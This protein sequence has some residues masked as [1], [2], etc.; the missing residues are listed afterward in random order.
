MKTVCV[1]LTRMLLV[2]GCAYVV[3]CRE[4]IPQKVRANSTTT[5]RKTLPS[6]P[7]AESR[8]LLVHSYHPEYPWVA[9]ITR[10]VQETLEGNGVEFEVFYMDTKRKTDERWKV[11]AGELAEQKVEE[12]KPD[13]VIAADDNAQQY[14][15][16]KYIGKPLP[17]VF[18]GVGADPSK[19]GYPAS[20][21]TGVLER[22]HFRSTLEYAHALR[23]IK[24]I[25]V[26]SS[27]DPTSVAAFAFMK[28]DYID[29][30]VVEW[31]LVSDFDKWKETVKRYNET[32]DAF[33]IR[34]YQTVKQPG[35]RENVAPREVMAW[36]AKHATVPT[37]AFHDFE[38]EDGVLMGVVKSG[39]EEGRKAARYAVE[40]LKGT[41]MS[42][43]PITRAN[44]G[45]KMIN[46]ETA[47][48]LG[49]ALTEEAMQGGR[50]VPE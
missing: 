22:P 35:S 2:A 45:T 13:V 40:I 4:D 18:C 26:M 36:T 47:A 44:I 9:T 34:S 48:R 8:V 39:E 16:M 5:P 15:A 41:P 14:F 6:K 3:G 11:R 32:V 20:N 38:I 23:P 46:R 27:N 43:L 17:F 24:R 28:E 42:S 1:T 12:Y 19:Y 49:I 25:A 50:I 10:G 31:N 33:V 37:L 30:E 21:I 7:L 29:T